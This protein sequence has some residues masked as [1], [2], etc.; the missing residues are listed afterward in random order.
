MK[1]TAENVRAIGTFLSSYHSDL[2]YIDN[3][4]KH[5]KKHITTAEYVLENKG[6]FKTFINEFRVARNIPLGNTHLVLNETMF[7]I[8]SNSADDVDGFAYHLNKKNVTT[9]KKIMT[10]LAS[11]ILFLNN[12]WILLPFDN[13]AK[14]SL[15]QR[16][17]RYEDYLPKMHSYRNEKESEIEQMLS[18]VNKHVKIIEQDFKHLEDIKIIRQNRFVDKL[19]WSGGKF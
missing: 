17:N 11:K 8:S 2:S 4:Q 10:S 9:E 3:F 18:T 15:K 16:S 12:P 5:K 7:W 6:M 19:L 14:K 13:L 1:L